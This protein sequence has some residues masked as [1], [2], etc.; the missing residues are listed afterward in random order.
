MTTRPSPDSRSDS[1]AARTTLNV[2]LRFVS[3]SFCHSCSEKRSARWIVSTTPAFATTASQPGTAASTASRSRMSKS[4]TSKPVTEQPA[5]DSSSTVARPM[6]PAAPVTI[7]RRPAGTRASVALESIALPVPVGDVGGVLVPVPGAGIVVEVARRV[8]RVDGIADPLDREDLVHERA[9]GAVDGEAF[10]V[11]G[12]VVLALHHGVAVLALVAA[13][14]PQPLPR[15]TGVHP[16]CHLL[17][18]LLDGEGARLGP[19]AAT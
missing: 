18:V 16:E 6:P 10:A 3:M 12:P 17:G 19:R 8:A 14:P 15:A 13:H 5:A 4:S 11:V 2:P 1:K 7:T 9:V